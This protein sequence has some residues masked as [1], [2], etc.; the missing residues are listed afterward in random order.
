MAW[1]VDVLCVLESRV[2]SPCAVMPALDGGG[3]YSSRYSSGCS[4]D[5]SGCSRM[6]VEASF[7]CEALRRGREEVLVLD[8][9]GPEHYAAGHIRGAVSVGLPSLMLRRLASG[10]LSLPQVVRHLAPD[11]D[12]L[13]ALSRCGPLVLYDHAD[14]RHPHAPHA[15]SLM[16]VLCRKFSQEGRVAHCLTGGS[17]Q[18]RQ[19]F[20]CLTVPQT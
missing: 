4:R 3:E 8:C 7:L 14:P 15:P 13:A 17:S 1:G 18:L 20:P 10:K 16:A 5:S 9:R 2:R 19:E 12:R 6:S 11:A